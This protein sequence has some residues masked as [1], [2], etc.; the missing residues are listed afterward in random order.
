MRVVFD[1]ITLAVPRVIADLVLRNNVRAPL[2][3]Q[4]IHVVRMSSSK[5]LASDLM[6]WISRE[7]SVRRAIGQK[8]LVRLDPE[9]KGLGI[10]HMLKFLGEVCSPFKNIPLHLLQSQPLS[11]YNLTPVPRVSV[12][13]E[14]RH[15]VLGKHVNI[16]RFNC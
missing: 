11:S 6:L 3:A 15:A 7:G 12:I 2:T 16:R 8:W 13:E 9:C 5:I 1:A 14:P 4:L 10:Q